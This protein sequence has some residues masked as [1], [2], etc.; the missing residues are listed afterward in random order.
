MEILGGAV[1]Y[2]LFGKK[3]SNGTS[4]TSKCILNVSV[5]LEPFQLDLLKGVTS[6]I[7]VLV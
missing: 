2:R 5:A 1:P 3:E 6:L 4:V 7:R